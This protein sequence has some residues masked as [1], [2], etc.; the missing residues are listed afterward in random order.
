M[1][2]VEGRFVAAARTPHR[3]PSPRLRDDY[4]IH[5]YPSSSVEAVLRLG[6]ASLGLVFPECVAGDLCGEGEW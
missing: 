6:I 5:L 1:I 2:V 4:P 3:P